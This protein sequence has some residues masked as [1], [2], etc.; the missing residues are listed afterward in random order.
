MPAVGGKTERENEGTAYRR[1]PRETRV[2]V[3]ICV[4]IAL[5]LGEVSLIN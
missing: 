3:Q 5:R 1:R 2:Q 4:L